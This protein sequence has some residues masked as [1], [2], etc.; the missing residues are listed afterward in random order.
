MIESALRTLALADSTVSGLV[1]TRMYPLKLPQDPTYPAVTY[2]RIS[3]PRLYDHGGETGMAE[4][5]FQIDS[6]G[7]SYSSAKSAAAAVR[8]AIEG[9]RGT[10]GGTEFASIF[11]VN[12]SD[13]YEPQEGDEG[14]WRVSTDYW[15][16]YY[17]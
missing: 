8:E 14:V 7:A 4:G 10:T 13:S 5:R 17:E 15:I 2:T 16:R 6:W 9:Y 3:G 11:C 1:G 12:D